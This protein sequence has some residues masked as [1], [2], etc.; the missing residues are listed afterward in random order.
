MSMDDVFA[1]F[2]DEEKE[3]EEETPPEK[4]ELKPEVVEEEVEEP[5]EVEKP[6]AKAK[7]K[8]KKKPPTETEKQSIDNLFDEDA[9]P[10]KPK[11]AKKEYDLSPEKVT[12]QRSFMIYALKGHGKTGLAFSFPGK[13]ACVSLD[14]NST[15]I[16]ETLYNSDERITVYDGIRYLKK[17]S[18]EDWME[19]AV[20]SFNYIC[21]LLDGPIKESKPDWI[22]IDGTE[23]LIRDVCEMTMRCRCNLQA[24]EGFANLNLWKERNMYADQIHMLALKYAKRGVIYTA[25]IDT[26]TLKI[27]G[28]HIV[29]EE[30]EPKWAANI[31]TQVGT[32]IFLKSE[33]TEDTREF[34][35]TVESSKNPKI[36]TGAHVN[37]T[38][39]GIKNIIKAS[40]KKKQ[41]TKE[42]K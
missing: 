34:W 9:P 27:T 39:G 16:K 4:P 22:V 21:N 24:F 11:R 20:E 2:E 28:G 7:A 37:I 18:S 12:L 36:R 10:A 1:E 14:R 40:K 13:I 29:E 35:A 23:I 8:A 32:V 42:D 6:K 26:T 30:R 38:G 41:K 15:R 17:T 3:E 31:K 25:Y 33:Q 19:S 5:K